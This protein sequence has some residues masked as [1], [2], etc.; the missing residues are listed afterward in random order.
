MTAEELRELIE[1]TIEQ[2]LHEILGDAEAGLT[3]RQ[4]LRD[5]LLRQKQAVGSGERG[6][7]YDDVTRRL[8]LARPGPLD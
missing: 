1:T 8:D 7:G 4:A 3:M 5:R 2:K 6:E